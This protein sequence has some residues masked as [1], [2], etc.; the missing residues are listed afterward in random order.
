M[1]RRKMADPVEVAG[2]A[3][4]AVEGAAEAADQVLPEGLDAKIATLVDEALAKAIGVVHDKVDEVDRRVGALNDAVA[5]NH[6][7]TL[8]GEVAKI[9]AVINVAAGIDIDKLAAQS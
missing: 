4:A 6:P 5:L 3:A 7:D 1:R 9:K 2:A 8:A